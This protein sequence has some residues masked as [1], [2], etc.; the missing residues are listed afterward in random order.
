MCSTWLKVSLTHT[1]LV[2]KGHMRTRIIYIYTCMHIYTYDY[3]YM[4]TC[5]VCVTYREYTYAHTHTY[6][7]VVPH[8]AVAEVSKIGN[9]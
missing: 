2:V 3:I 1:W 9:L 8:K 6:I 7:P 5:V 4:C